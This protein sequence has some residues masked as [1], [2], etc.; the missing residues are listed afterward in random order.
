[1]VNKD[2]L[3][4][5]KKTIQEFFEK[6]GFEVE[7]EIKQ[8]EEAVLP[9]SL[10]VKEPQILIGDRGQTLADIQ[11]ILRQ[12]LNRKIDTDERFI[13]DIDINDYKKQKLDYLKELARS[14]ADD[15]ALYRKEKELI[16]MSAFERR[17]VH[18]EIANRDDV[19]TESIGNGPERR[20]VIKPSF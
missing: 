19:E 5:I 9:I 12:M 18:M 6:A 13:I 10:N 8:Q 15:V 7:V 3:E 4:I 11:K 14:M 17:I 16:P 1:M 20:I 2:N